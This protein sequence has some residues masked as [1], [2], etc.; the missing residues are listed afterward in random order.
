MKA[1]FSVLDKYFSCGSN[2]KW[3]ATF[4]LLEVWVIWVTSI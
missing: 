2:C 1:I 3:N 4:W